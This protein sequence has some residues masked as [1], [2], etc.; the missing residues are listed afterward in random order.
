MDSTLEDRVKRLQEM[1][2]T[3]SGVTEL[4]QRYKNIHTQCVEKAIASYDL[5]DKVRSYGRLYL[6]EC[7]QVW[8]KSD[9]SKHWQMVK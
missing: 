8:Q 2:F 7:G 4:D 9:L 5:A 1:G 6:F 3:V